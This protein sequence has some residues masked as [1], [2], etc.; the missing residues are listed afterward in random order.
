[1]FSGC[2]IFLSFCGN[3]RDSQQHAG[4]DGRPDGGYALP[5]RLD[6]PD[7]KYV[8]PHSL[9]EISGLSWVGENRLASIQDEKANIYLIEL[10]DPPGISKHDFGKDGDYEDIALVG[11]TAYV[12]RNDGKVYR[13]KH[14]DSDKLKTKEY[15]TRLSA[16]NNAEGMEYDPQTNSLLIACKGSPSIGKDNPYEGSR[17]VYRFDLESKKL[18]TEPFFLIDLEKLD[19]YRDRGTF[20]KFSTGLAKRLR[21]ID[22]ETPFMPSGISIHPI[23][24]D[25]YLISSVGKLLVVTD[26]LGRIL[27]IQDLDAEMFRQPEGI[28]FSPAGDLYISSEGRGGKGYILKF[29]YQMDEQAR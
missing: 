2:L 3:S 8:L 5:Y 27:D 10:R 16:R 24:G 29:K 12:L 22:N 21:L 1:M 23:S 18:I 4:P 15:S 20:M 7:A 26:R 9:Q 6:Q 28:C 17:A 14:F 25:I 13:V 11:K 19:G